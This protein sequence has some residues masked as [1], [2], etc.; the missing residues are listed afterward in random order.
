MTF[1]QVKDHVEVTKRSVLGDSCTAAAKGVQS[2]M[3]IILLNCK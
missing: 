2:N 3:Q 1:P